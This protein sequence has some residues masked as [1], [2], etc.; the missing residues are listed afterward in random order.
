M[1]KRNMLTAS[2]AVL[3]LT[4]ASGCQQDDTRA[5]DQKL[6][7]PQVGTVSHYGLTLDQDASPTEVTYVLLQALREDFLAETQAER[8]AAL[9]KQFDVSAANLLRQ[10][11]PLSISGDEFLNRI[12]F[13]WTPVVAHYV[14]SLDFTWEDAQARLV[15]GNM[16]QP[17]KLGGEDIPATKVLVELADPSGDPNAQVV[18]GVSMVKDAGYWRVRKLEY[19]MR[20]R[21]IAIIPA[22]T[23]PDNATP[24]QPEP[25]TKEPNSTDPTTSGGS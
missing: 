13:L 24:A 4:L 12:V 10:A 14:D 18:L 9:D 3:V 21:E 17:F 20:N 23:K 22:A 1:N 5:G 19:D 2:A 6:R 11:N 16:A 15:E 8:D 7:S 25:S